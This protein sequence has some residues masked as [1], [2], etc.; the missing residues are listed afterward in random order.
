MTEHVLHVA[1]AACVEADQRWLFRCGEIIYES[2]SSVPRE[3][4]SDRSSSLVLGPLAVVGHCAVFSINIY[5]I[6]PPPTLD[7]RDLIIEVV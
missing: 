7:R 1:A 3:D 5:V 6:A 4:R 2:V